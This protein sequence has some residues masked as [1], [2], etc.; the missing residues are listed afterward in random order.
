LGSFM[1]F[2]LDVTHDTFDALNSPGR[3]EDDFQDLSTG[4]SSWKKGSTCRAL[5]RKV[6]RGKSSHTNRTNVSCMTPQ[7]VA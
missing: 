4:L 2:I 1:G 3:W 5:N 7:K 6:R